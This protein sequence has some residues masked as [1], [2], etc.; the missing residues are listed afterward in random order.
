MHQGKKMNS[1]LSAKLKAEDQKGSILIF[2]IN[3]SGLSNSI[4]TATA[5]G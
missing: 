4:L 3:I 1:I 2:S 5:E